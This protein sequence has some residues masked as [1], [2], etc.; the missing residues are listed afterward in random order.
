MSNEFNRKL[1]VAYQELSKTG[2]WRYNFDPPIFRVLRKTGLNVRPPY[3]NTYVVNVLVFGIMFT[4]LFG[5]ITYF[6][7][8][9]RGRLESYSLTTVILTGVVFGLLVPY[10]LNNAKKKYSLSDWEDL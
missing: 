8:S 4:V 3:Y 1:D 7:D 10:I 9:L 2:K 5:A 6:L